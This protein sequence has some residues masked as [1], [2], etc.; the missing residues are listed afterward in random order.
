MGRALLGRGWA[1]LEVGGPVSAGDWGPGQDLAG[2][3]PVLEVKDWAGVGLKA[4]PT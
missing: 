1:P 3:T 4:Q 2:Q